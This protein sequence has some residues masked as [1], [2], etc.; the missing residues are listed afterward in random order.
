MQEAVYANAYVKAIQERFNNDGNLVYNKFME[1]LNQYQQ[2]QL[3]VEDILRY[4][5]YFILILFI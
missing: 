4:V 3:S 2:G 1:V 5:W